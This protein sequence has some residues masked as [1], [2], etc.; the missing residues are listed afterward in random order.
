MEF[1]SNI[2][3]L[4][5]IV[6]VERRRTVVLE[7]LKEF[8]GKETAQL[9]DRYKFLDLYP[10]THTELRSIGYN[11]VCGVMTGNASRATQP[12]E[13]SETQAIIPR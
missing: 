7:N 6:K 12:Q 8:E 4:S 1:E 9:V 5:S 10:C 2:G 13:E 11:E 3:D